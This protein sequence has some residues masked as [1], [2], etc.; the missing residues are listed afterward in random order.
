MD[1]FRLD[2][3]VAV[4]TGAA[5][6]IGRATA[7]LFAALGAGLTLIDLKE[8]DL[9]STAE[10]IKKRGG[11]VE[12]GVADVTDYSSLSRCFE[13]FYDRYGRIDI[14][15]NNAGIWEFT[16]WLDLPLGNFHRMMAVNFM[17]C[18]HC[19][20]LALPKMLENGYGKIVSVASVAGREGSAVGSSHYA[21]SKGAIIAFTRSLA[22]EFGTR[23]ININAVCPGLVMTVMGQATGDVGLQAYTS[24]SALKRGGRPE[25]VA[26]VICFLA[27]DAAA[28]VT[29]QAWNVCGGYRLD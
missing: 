3:K 5:N 22:K 4:I 24:R 8:A 29:G 21:S 15:V 7:E 19:V 28:F 2:E 16:P 10:E 18:V 25:E 14:L 17:G 6:G 27:S 20:K 26:N 9:N 13:R 11:E 12:T 1:N 23:G